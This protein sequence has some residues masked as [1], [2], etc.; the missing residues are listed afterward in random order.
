MDTR[1]RACFLVVLAV[2][3]NA[4]WMDRTFGESGSLVPVLINRAR[5]TVEGPLPFKQL[6]VEYTTPYDDKLS[7]DNFNECLTLRAQNAEG[8]KCELDFYSSY[9]C[10]EIVAAPAFD[11][12]EAVLC[13]RRGDGRGTTVRHEFLDVYKWRGRELKQVLCVPL[14]GW[15]AD[16]SGR[17]LGPRHWE[18]RWA[19]ADTDGDGIAEVLLDRVGEIRPPNTAAGVYKW[20]ADMGRYVVVSQKE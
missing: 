10:F 15:V 9:G 8:Q 17:G 3:V 12:V 18:H 20:S 5:S 16:D 2:V 13:V 7:K 11:N 1:G 6:S 14:G 19:V 4:V